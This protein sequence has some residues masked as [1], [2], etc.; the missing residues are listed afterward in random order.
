[1]IL[2]GQWHRRSFETPW[3]S[4]SEPSST[5]HAFF[6]LA[7]SP[8]AGGKSSVFQDAVFDIDCEALV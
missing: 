4:E 5:S 7:G 8:R 1:M 2:A 6:R 3:R